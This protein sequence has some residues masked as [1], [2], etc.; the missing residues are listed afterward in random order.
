MK[1][2]GHGSETFCVE[3][4]T[5]RR[6]S[7]TAY[8]SEK[9]TVSG[10]GSVVHIRTGFEERRFCRRLPCGDAAASELFDK[11]YNVWKIKDWKNRYFTMRYHSRGYRHDVLG[12]VYRRWIIRYTEKGH[13]YS[14]RGDIV[15]FY[16]EDIRDTV[17][18]LCGYDPVPDL[19]FMDAGC[20]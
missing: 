6:G 4:R 9:V 3:M 15:P 1:R 8:G 13:I 2:C 14:V 7:M 5:Y 11:V 19:F 12:P 16:A 18:G 10:R 20:N 17:L